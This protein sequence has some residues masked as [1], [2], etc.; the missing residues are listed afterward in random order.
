MNGWID[1]LMADSL[2]TSFI[3]QLILKNFV[4]KHVIGSEEENSSISC[5]YLDKLMD[6]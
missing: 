6:R 2:H 5:D 3:S 1:R 4:K